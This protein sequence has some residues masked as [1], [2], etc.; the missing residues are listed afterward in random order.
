MSSVFISLLALVTSS[1]A[2]L[3]VNDPSAAA[4]NAYTQCL[5]QFMQRSLDDRMS[6]NDFRAALP[7]QC[8]QQEQ[9]FRQA[10]IAREASF[11]TPRA[12]AEETATMEVDDARANFIQLFE[13]NQPS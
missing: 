4:R 9:A 12:E 5:R 3:Q 8:T 2:A 6:L 1:G 11:R 13:N 10:L 7:Q